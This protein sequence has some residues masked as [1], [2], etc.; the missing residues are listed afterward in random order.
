[1]QP[2]DTVFATGP[3]WAF[4]PRVVRWVGV[5]TLDLTTH[6]DPELAA[7][8]RIRAGALAPGRPLRDLVLSPDHC[9]LADG[10]L[11]RAFRLINGVSVVQERPASV[12]YVHVELDHHALLLAEGVAAESYLDEGHRGFFAGAIAVPGPLADRTVAAC[13]PFAPD[14]AFAERIWQRVAAR[15]QAPAPRPPAAPALRLIAG[16]RHLRPAAVLGDRHLYALPPGVRVLR[17]V[18]PA[19]RPTDSRPWAEDRRRLGVRVAGVTIDGAR[20]PLDGPH[21]GRGWWCAEPDGCRWTDG[22]ASLA[23]PPAAVLEVRLSG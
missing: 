13:A 15:A 1:L 3:D 23:L 21:A 10:H 22:D 11:L 19:L 2:G 17:L 6:P 14:D 9:V 7:P 20:L 4:Y 16:E 8:I 5:R 18:S 12:T